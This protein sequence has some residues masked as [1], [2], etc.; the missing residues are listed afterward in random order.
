LL[1]NDFVVVAV[2]RNEMIMA[3]HFLD[4]YR[5]LGVKCFIFVDNCSDDGTR[6]YL[7]AQHDTVVYSVETAYKH[8]HYGVTWQQ[9]VLAN[10]CLGKWVLLADADEFLVFDGCE[11]KG[12][13]SFI[14][15]IER[16][17][18]DAA[19][20]HMIDMYPFGDLDEA[21]FEKGAPF[22]VAPH[23]DK[24]AQIELK[25]GGGH[26]SNSRNFVNGL[27]HRLAPSRINSYV[28]Q[29]Y[30]LFKYKPWVRL[31]E[32]IHYSG[33]LRVAARPAYFAHFKYHAGFKSKVQ[34]EIK[35]NQHF[36]GAE[37]YRRYAG[38]LAE[39][40]GRFGRQDLSVK[41]LSSKSFSELF[42]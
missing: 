26:F 1:T 32:G 4:H 18:K 19:F 17:G 24:N 6:E 25:F 5:K 29:K 42:K 39:G 20:V 11:T 37:E 21:S 33:N 14:G 3:P 40:S 34:T 13:A 35:R 41:Y 27:R 36:N 23:F 22:D 10:H 12:I 31:T 38:M 30:A 28:S 9:A 7:L 8:S 2:V 15:E 16:E